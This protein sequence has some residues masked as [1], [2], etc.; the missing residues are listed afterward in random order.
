MTFGEKT[1][2]T[3]HL[4]YMYIYMYNMCDKKNKNALSTT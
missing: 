3:M 1:V 2:S 4:K